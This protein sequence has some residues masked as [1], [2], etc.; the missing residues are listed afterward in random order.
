MASV[1]NPVVAG[2]GGS[3]PLLATIMGALQ[4]RTQNP[5]QSFSEQSANLQ[6]ADPTMVL[7]QLEQVNQI[8]G[9]LFVKTFQNLPN[10]AN[11]ISATMKQLSRA[12]KEAQQGSSVSEVVGKP[13]GPQPIN[14][15]AA[16]SGENSSPGM[17]A[18]A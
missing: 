14:F 10:L 9:V 3:S 1:P 11:Q 8:L 17:P 12:L 4:N 18:A 13:A 16:Q 6:G 15:S 5:A 2:G 7:R